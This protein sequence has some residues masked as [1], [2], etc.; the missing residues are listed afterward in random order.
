MLT[1]EYVR[2]CFH[3]DADTGALVWRNVNSAITQT[4][5]GQRD[6]PLHQGRQGQYGDHLPIHA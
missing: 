3:Y 1:A 5:G 6:P 4:T 2:Q